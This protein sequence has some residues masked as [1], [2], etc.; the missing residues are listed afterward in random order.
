MRDFIRLQNEVSRSIDNLPRLIATEA[1]NFSKQRFVSQNWVDHTTKTW[2]ARKRPRGSKARSRGAILV[3]S[4]RLKRS[5]RKVTVS[6]NIVIIGTDVPYAAAHN[7]GVRQN[8]T[9]KSHT[10]TSHTGKTYS[11]Q[12]HTKNMNLPQR[13]FMG[14]SQALVNRIERTATA[15][16]M[17]GIQ[18]GLRN[19]K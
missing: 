4:G 8:V 16:I 11:V 7:Y 5:I 12:S 10:R 17:R 13:Q 2:Q 15:E 19:L 9:V 14:E 1:V 6:K 18:K 3:S